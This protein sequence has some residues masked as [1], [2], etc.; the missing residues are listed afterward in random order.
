M[1]KGGDGGISYAI[2]RAQHE[3]FRYEHDMIVS[4]ASM[5]T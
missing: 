1:T 5:H 3:S 4:F 2:P